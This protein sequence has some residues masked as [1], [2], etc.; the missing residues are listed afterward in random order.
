MMAVAVCGTT[1]DNLT[2]KHYTINRGYE[3]PG[4]TAMCG[5]KLKF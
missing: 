3:M 2:D 5:F 4:F 1:L